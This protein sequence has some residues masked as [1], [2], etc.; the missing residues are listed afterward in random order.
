MS[1][2]EGTTVKTFTEMRTVYIREFGYSNGELQYDWIDDSGEDSFSLFPSIEAA[3]ED[4][5]R[6]S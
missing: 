6:H 5:R 2:E 3:E 4:A 1:D